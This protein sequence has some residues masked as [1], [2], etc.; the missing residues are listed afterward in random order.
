MFERMQDTRLAIGP[1]VLDPARATLQ[2]DGK[3]IA[4]GQRG[5]ALLA[6]LVEADGR[7][8][9]RAALIERGWP[10]VIVEESNLTV[11]MATLRRALGTHPDDQEWIATVPRVGYRLV[12]PAE[13]SESSGRPSVAVLPFSNFSTDPGQEH[14]ADGMVDDLITALSRFKS[15]AVIARH[16][17]FAYKGRN[18]DVRE[19]G[20]ALGV[21]YVLE[22]SVR[23]SGDEVRVTAQLVEA[24]AGAHIWAETYDGTIGDV[25]DFQDRITETVIGSIEPRIRKAEI[26]R[27]RRKRPESLDAYDLYHRAQALISGTSHDGYSQAVT[28]LDRALE[29]D[30]GFA[31]SLA[32]AG[33]A[34]SKRRGQAGAPPIEV[35][36]RDS[37]D[38]CERALAADGDDAVLL[39]ICA[40]QFAEL[41]NEGARALELVRR[42]LSLNPNS[43]TVVNLS[44]YVLRGQELFDEA[45]DCHLRAMKL[46]PN[47]PET[48]WCLAGLAAANLGAGRFEEALVWGLRA[49]ETAG[50]DW[51]RLV[52]AATYAHLNR[53]DEAFETLRPVLAK[54]PV[55]TVSAV[56][57]SEAPSPADRLLADGVRKAGLPER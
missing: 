15:F 24:A 47:A 11:Q 45:I 16:S 22:G 12:V 49:T 46:M 41:S 3:P 53:L 56:F 36:R 30:P 25:F 55:L 31:P 38:L 1:F 19:V 17:S 48:V 44:G 5:L 34:R 40:C 7:V 9:T 6:A 14:F 54:R 28:L 18:V 2:R 10:G 20:R 21:R 23:R 57:H 29:L 50:D 26:Q 37:L 39:A 32:M 43:F 13:A 4:L 51:T 52:V 42:A 27:S 8:V 35:D 33:W